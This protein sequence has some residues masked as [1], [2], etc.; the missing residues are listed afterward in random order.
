M[1]EVLHERPADAARRFGG[2]D[3]GDGLGVKDEIEGPALS[4]AEN[5]VRGFN[6]VG[7][8]NLNWHI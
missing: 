1:L 2:P 8:D 5:I 4:L 6:A 3:N 7:A